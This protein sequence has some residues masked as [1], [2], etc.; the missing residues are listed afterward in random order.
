M[1][2]SLKMETDPG[3]TRLTEIYVAKSLQGRI[4][5][6]ARCADEVRIYRP[7]DMYEKVKTI[8]HQE[9]E[10]QKISYGDRSDMVIYSDTVNAAWQR[11]GVMDSIDRASAKKIKLPIGHYFP[12]IWRGIYDDDNYYSYNGIDARGMYGKSY[13]GSNVAVSSIFDALELLF[14]YVEPL[15]AVD[16]GRQ[17]LQPLHA[18]RQTLQAVDADRQA[19][20]ARQALDDDR[21][22]LQALDDGRQALQPLHAGRQACE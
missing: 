12:R 5:A 18:G 10:D 14:R 19:R 20:Q 16:A 21:Q 7:D 22:D 9:W 6:F 17:A 8:T 4:V 13:T 15:Q 11:L 2:D 1:P 3:I